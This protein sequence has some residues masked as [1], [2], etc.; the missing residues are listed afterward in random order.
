M[1]GDL[2]GNPYPTR[3]SQRHHS[4]TAPRIDSIPHDSTAAPIA[5]IDPNPEGNGSR[6]A[7]P[8]EVPEV[9]LP[10]LTVRTHQLHEAMSMLGVC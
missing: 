7:S 2:W 6:P 1:S 5:P 10:R 3:R 9:I 4:A 8:P